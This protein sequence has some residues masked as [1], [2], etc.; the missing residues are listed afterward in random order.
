MVQR[1][2]QSLLRSKVDGQR[3]PR[4]SFTWATVEEL[5]ELCE[6]AIRVM[7]N[8]EALLRISGP[9][10]LFGDIHGQLADLLMLFAT[11]GSP[12]HRTHVLARA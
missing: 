8:E 12:N 1:I 3:R 4:E 10:K 6:Q 9:C 2:I 7:R 11:F 5:L